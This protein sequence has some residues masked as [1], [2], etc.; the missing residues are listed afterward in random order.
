[1]IDVVIPARNEA[2][3]IK[4]V[5]LAF[6]Q[7]PWIGRIIVVV[8]DATNDNTIMEV[9]GYSTHTT[10]GPK[11]GNNKGLNCQWGLKLVKTSHV[12]FCDADLTGLTADHVDKLTG[13]AEWASHY[14]LIAPMTIGVPDF[15]DRSPVPWPVRMDVFALMSGQRCLP[16]SLA[17]SV[18][19][20]GYCMEDQLNREA[21]RQGIP[22]SFVRLEGVRG[23][24]RENSRRM[25]ELRRDREWLAKNWKG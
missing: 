10:L 15:P 8:D 25:A 21:K 19:L 1:M 9:Y 22:L 23:K 4:N 3:T 17:R 5:C 7:C 11:G 12:C 2:D 6:R 16:T 13:P 24:V 18:D 14:N 20:H